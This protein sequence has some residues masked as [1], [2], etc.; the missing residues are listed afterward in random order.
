[1]SLRSCEICGEQR[2]TQRCHILSRKLDRALK[3]YVINGILY[4]EL[5][6]LY[7]CPNHHWALDHNLLT[8]SELEK[9]G[10]KVINMISIIDKVLDK[11]LF[12]IDRESNE[13]YKG[14]RVKNILQNKTIRERFSE[15]IKG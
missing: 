4:Q 5:N 2:M 8:P 7:L 12:G 13:F 3:N 11:F 1:M 9:I 15:Y 6:I 14:Y 10:Q